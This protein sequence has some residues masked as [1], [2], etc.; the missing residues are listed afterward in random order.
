MIPKMLSP[1]IGVSIAAHDVREDMTPLP[2]SDFP[3]GVTPE[4]K[5]DTYADFITTPAT[6]NHLLHIS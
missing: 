6:N 2:R 3:E 1:A 5:A 4:A